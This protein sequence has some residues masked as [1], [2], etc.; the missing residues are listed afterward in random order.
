MCARDTRT[1][2]PEIRGVFELV[3]PR[4]RRMLFRIIAFSSLGHQNFQNFFEDTVLMI[5]TRLAVHIIKISKD[6]R[7]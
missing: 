2:E 5:C 4:L 7:L 3:L 1:R 6:G